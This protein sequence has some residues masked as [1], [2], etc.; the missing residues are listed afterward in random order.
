MVLMCQAAFWGMLS[1]QLGVGG[2]GPDRAREAVT[3]KPKLR[4]GTPKPGPRPRPP[5]EEDTL[6]HQEERGLSRVCGKLPLH[7]TGH[8]LCHTVLSF[9]CPAFDTCITDPCFVVEEAD[10]GSRVRSP[11]S[12]PGRSPASHHPL[13]PRVS[14]GNP[15]SGVHVAPAPWS[16][17][18]GRVCSTLLWSGSLR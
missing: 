2:P 1:L 6:T 5:A 10:A 17:L 18:S 16:P 15:A 14:S 9:S 13:L 8:E 4:R 7:Q 12:W 11:V 3:W